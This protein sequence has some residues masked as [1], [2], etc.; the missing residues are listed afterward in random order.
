[1]ATTIKLKNSVTTTNAPSSLAQGEVAINVTD[2]KVWVGNAATTPVQLLGT[3]SDGSFTNV[4][5]SGVASFADGTVS[6]P[7]ITNIGD[8]NTGIFFPAADTIAFSEGGV[9]SMRIDASSNV[10]IGA[11]STGGYR[12]SVNDS[13]VK[14]SVGSPIKLGTAT[15]GASD[16]ELEIKRSASGSGANY[17][18]Q[19]VEQ[20][21]DF[22][23]LVLQ[24]SGGNVGIG[25]SSPTS[26]L[27]VQR[28]NGTATYLQLFQT[29]LESWQIGMPATVA[30]LTFRNSGTEQM[31]LDTSGNLMIG[32]TTSAVG[33]KMTVTN[34]GNGGIYVNQTSAGGWNYQSNAANLAGTFYHFQTIAAGTAVGGI[35]SSSTTTSF[36]TTSDYRLKENVLPMTGAL[37]TVSALKPVTYTWKLDGSEGQGF[38]A[39]ELQSVVPD[40]VTGEKDAVNEDGT[41]KPQ[42]IDTSFL[43]A[44]LTAALQEAHGLIKDLQAR[45]EALE[46]K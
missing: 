2:K 14:T 29:S 8:T 6:L 30:A 10:S 12:F 7:A 3:G 36:N 20:G 43:V 38:I 41:I 25:T 44:T 15:G 27:H 26:A 24:P 16:F 39:H 28:P 5:V 40:A 22:R 37:A 19:S 11:A 18:I 21:V 34:I 31:R 1:M 35:T 9:E 23:N 33:G 17:S 4:S 13:A 32:T 42:G 46:S 45:V